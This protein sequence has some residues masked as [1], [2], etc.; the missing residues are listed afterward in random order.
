ML[1]Q[2]THGSP[3][4]IWVPIKYGSTIYTGGV[5]SCDNGDV[6]AKDGV[7]MMEAA[8]G[9]AN[10]TNADMPIGIVIGNNLRK[11]L[12]DTTALTE[13]ITSATPHDSTSEFVSTGGPYPGGA[14]EAFAKIDII[15]P[16]TV[17]KSGLVDSAMGTAPTVSV[18]SAAVTDGLTSVGVAAAS[19]A[20]IQGFSTVYFRTGANKGTYRIND[21]TA[22]TTSFA[23]DTPTYADIAAGD[24]FVMVNVLPFGPCNVQLL[25]TY[26]TA[27]DIDEA[28]TSD[29]LFIDVYRLDLSEANK[30]Y[31]EFRWNTTNFNPIEAARA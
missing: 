6:D 30:E 4:A 8:A 31:V 14:R 12:Y 5:V 20:S 9:A 11:P 26:S 29:Y 1:M 25:T 17:C 15:D 13:Y 10:T 3:Q 2:V 28:C 16:C 7:E 23:W 22:S 27:F 21:N 24:T 18:V 19:V